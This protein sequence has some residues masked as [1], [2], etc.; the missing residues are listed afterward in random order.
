VREALLEALAEQELTPTHEF[1]ITPAVSTRSG[2]DAVRRRAGARSLSPAG[3]GVA[4]IDVAVAPT[5][6]A[7]ILVEQDGEFSWHFPDPAPSARPSG[8]RGARRAASV[9]ARAPSTVRISVRL[10]PS[11]RRT[12]DRASRPGIGIGSLLSKAKGIVL[13]FV[14]RTVAGVTIKF[15]ERN[16][17]KGLVV[18]DGDDPTAW[19]RIESID[20]LSLPDG[21]A[22][23]LLWVHGTFSSTAGSFG[24]LTATPDGRALLEQ[25]RQRYDA[26]IGFDHASLSETPQENAADLIERLGR[27]QRPMQIDAITYSRGG[28]VFRSLVEHV[29]PT[30]AAHPELGSAVFVG[31]PNAGTLLA[32]PQNWKALIDLY[33]NLAAGAFNLLR[34]FPQ[35]A[36]VGRIF[37]ELISGLGALVKYLADVIVTEKRVPGLAAQAPSS[38]F[39]RALNET[40]PGQPLPASCRYLA[41]TSN[42]DP[43]A[44]LA[45][46]K[47]TGLAGSFLGRLADG[48][49]DRLMRETNDL[50]VNNGSMKVI[51]PGA[52]DFIDAALD[53]GNSPVV[54]HTVY[55]AQPQ[56]AQQLRA[57]LLDENAREGLVARRGALR[58][59]PS[60][61]SPFTRVQYHVQDGPRRERIQPGG[62]S[63]DADD[64][65]RVVASSRRAGRRAGFAPVRERATLAD[66]SAP[67]E[68]A[69]ESVEDAAEAHVRQLFGQPRSAPPPEVIAAAAAPPGRRRGFGAAPTPEP[70]RARSHAPTLKRQET[71]VSPLTADEA[72]HVVSFTQLH[73]QIPIFG[74]RAIVEL[75]DEHDLV[76]ARAKLARVDGVSPVPAL[77]AEQAFES[78]STFARIGSGDGGNA[79]ESRPAPQLTFYHDRAND[80]WHLAYLFSSIQGLPASWRT[81]T[82][83]TRPGAK[84]RIVPD[85]HRMGPSPRQR[86]PMLDYLVDANDGSVVYFYSVTPTVD[87]DPSTDAEQPLPAGGTR[88]GGRRSGRSAVKKADGRTAKRSRRTAATGINPLPAVCR[89]VDDLGVTRSFDA[90]PLGG[91]A[92]ELNDPQ[93]KIRTF[94]HAGN[95][96]D[97]TPIPSTPIR[98]ATFDFATNAP[99]GVSAHFF[100]S[101]VFDFFNSVLIR[102]GI[103]DKG[104]EL[105][106][107][108][109]V[110]SQADQPP[111]EWHN[112]VWFK[113][114]MW[115]GRARGRSASFESFARHLDII[116]H[117]LTH[118]VTETTSDLIYRD[119]SGALNES[120]SDIFG[121]IIKNWELKGPDSDPDSWDWDIGVGLGSR[122]R[123]LRNMKNPRLTGDPDHMRDFVPLDP[124]DDF[125]GVHTYSNIH[126]KAAYNL[127]TAR[128]PGRAR[129]TKGPLVFRPREVAR[130]YYFTLQRLDRVATF[131]DVLETMFD[132]VKTVYPDPAEQ[133][134]KRA[135]LTEAYRKVGIPRE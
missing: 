40:G 25:A 8:R 37:S 55:F 102:R 43:E 31:V 84:R 107:V 78:L 7:V 71:Q 27:F 47:P 77:T 54:Y 117:E 19:R 56:V 23:I 124:E 121:V 89:G 104:M 61:R 131:E 93:R 94:D 95:D 2:R 29:L 21:R 130:L 51:D 109:N 6:S 88:R 111:P 9:T 24:A 10:G 79:T 90:L 4:A 15:L 126:N 73:A 30:S 66:V 62:G 17:R 81:T 59:S 100:S 20:D 103:D 33:T 45:G 74:T 52:G 60:P 76:A 5:E 92:F 63:S 41:V 120:F 50:V 64:T 58:V 98:H 82:R 26:V 110:S 115:Y 65:A 36:A 1:D 97:T 133:S 108:V 16:V 113:K 134:A 13:K 68:L 114:R 116:A 11:P 87:V 119:E 75:D 83:Q 39:I 118:G 38:D 129:G 105:V 80:R 28:L 3:A 123:P 86:F 14:A 35:T 49:V 57:W 18:M 69:T 128:T 99:A 12:S 122:G 53:F 132:V 34:L 101:R 70:P 44:A 106:N 127:L 72:I 85:G 125:G 91:G 48:L 135:A 96:I 42:F 22:R 112:A 67:G 46:T 32:E